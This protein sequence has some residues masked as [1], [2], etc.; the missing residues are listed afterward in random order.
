MII[1]NRLWRGASLALTTAVALA[2]PS[3][4]SAATLYWTP[5]T[6]LNWSDPGNWTPPTALDTVYFEDLLNPASAT[7]NA[8]LVNNIVDTNFTLGTAIYNAQAVTNSGGTAPLHYHT[9]LIPAGVGLGLAGLPGVPALRVGSDSPGYA[10][11]L[12]VATLLGPGNLFVTNNL[13]TVNVGQGANA[14]GTHRAVLDVSLLNSLAVNV[15]NLWVGASSVFDRAAGAVLLATNTTITTAPNVTAPGILLGRAM[16]NSAFGSITLGGTTS[17]NTD[18]LVVGGARS[19]YGANS[20]NFPNVLPG[21][22]L[23]ATFALRGSAGGSSRAAVFS[24]GDAS[25]TETN[26]AGIANG[27]G[28]GSS[29]TAASTADFTAGTVDIL[30]TNLFVGR[31]AADAVAPTT[32][33]SSAGTS[34]GSLIVNNGTVNALNAYVGLKLGTNKSLAIG[35][36]TARGNAILSVSNDLTLASVTSNAVSASSVT[37]TLNVNDNAL[38]QVGGNL[39]NRG[40]TATINLAGGTINLV[41]NG[42]VNVN[43]LAGFG[44]ISGSSSVIVSNTLTLGA[45]TTTFIRPGTLNLGGNLALASAVATK[46]KIG[47]ST[48]PGS[49]INDYLNVGGNLYLTNNSLDLTFVGIPA[50]GTY[51]LVD[52]AG[53]RSGAFNGIF[54]NTTRNLTFTLDQ[55]VNNHIRLVVA[56]G[57]P[58]ALTW[59][60]GV[61]GTWDLTNSA[62]W[63]GNTQK[64]YTF[65][66]VVFDDTGAQPIISIPSGVTVAPGNLTFNNNSVAYTMYA[67]G[68][69]T[70]PTGITKNGTGLVIWDPSGANDFVGPVNINQGTFQIQTTTYTALFGATNKMVTIAN[71]ATLDTYGNTVGSGSGV[72]WPLTFSGS[73]VNGIG[74]IAH[75]KLSSNPTVYS[76]QAT[77]AADALVSVAT[78]GLNMTFAGPSAPFNGVFDL[79]GHTLTVGGFGNIGFLNTLITN[80]GNILVTAPNLFLRDMILDGPGTLTLGTA[81]LTLGSLSGTAWTT[82]YVAKAISIGPSVLQALGGST[83][84]VPINSPISLSGAL[85]VSNAQPVRLAGVISG[86]FGLTKVG[87]N[88][89]N[90]AAANTYTGPTIVSANLL[91][92]EAT[93][94]LANSPL[95][96][97]DAPAALDVTAQPGAYTVPAGQTVQID[98]ALAGN[99]VVPIGATFAGSGL[100]PGSVAVLGGAVTPGVID[101]PRT[102]TVGALTLSNALLTYELDL[103][104]APGGN[105]NDLISVTQLNL[106]GTNVIKIVPLASLNTS[107]GQYTLFNYVGA[108]LPSAITNNF[109][110]VSDTRYTFSFVDPAATPGALMITVSG[111]RDGLV[112]QG[113]VPGAETAWDI[114]TTTNWNN[115]GSPEVF[116]NGDAVVFDDTSL[117]NEVDLAAGTL[118]PSAIGLGNSAQSYTFGGVGSLRAGAITNNGTAGLIFANA[119]N[120]ALSGAGLFL[121]AGS[122]TFSQPTNASFS[123]IL[124]GTSAAALNKQGTNVLSLVGNNGPTYAGAIN[125]NAGTLQPA[126]TNALGFGMVNVAPGATL[127][128]NGQEVD[129]PVIT[130]AGTGV[131]GLGAVN[132]TGGQRTNAL[133]RLTLA[134]DTTLGAQSRWDLEAGAYPAFVGNNYKLTKV[135]PADIWLNAL[136]DTSLGDIDIQQGRLVFAW[137]GTDLGN[138]ANTITVH[139]NASL[140]FAND[141][142]AGA[143]PATI[144]PGGDIEAFAVTSSYPT[145]GANNAYAGNVNFASAGIFR[146]ANLA[147]LSLSGTIQGPAGLVNA[148]RGSLTL[149]GS[150]AYAGDLTVNLGQVT[151]ASSN[152][153]PVGSTVTLNCTGLPSSDGVW[154]YV[155]NTATP[156]TV[157]LSLVSYRTPSGTLTPALTGNGIGVWGGP[158]NMVSMQSDPSQLPQVTFSGNTNLVVMQQVTQSGAPALNL[159]IYGFPGVVQFKAPLQFTGTM[160]MGSQGLG[161]TDLSQMYT[162]LELDS[163]GNAFTNMT[164]WRGKILIGADNALPVGCAMSIPFARTDNDARN[165]VDLHGH[166]Q[167]FANFPGAANGFAPL[168]FGNDSTNGDAALVFSSS[169]TNTWSAWLLDNINTNITTPRKMSLTVTSGGL[170]LA[171]L[172]W[173]NWTYGGPAGATNNTYSGATTVTGGALQ[174]DAPVTNSAITVSGTGVLAGSGPI[175]TPIVVGAGGTLSPGGATTMASAIGILTNYGGL[176]L[177]PGSKCY[178]EV[179][180]TSR[181][182]DWVAGST[183]A[184]GGTLIVT[185]VGAAAFTNGAYVKLFSATNYIAGPVAIQ[186]AFPGAGLMWDVTHLA[187]DGTLHVVPLVVPAVSLPLLRTDGNLSF[188]ITGSLGQPYTVRA[189]T[190]A[191]LPL[192]SWTVLQAGTLPSASYSFSDLTATNYPARFYRVSTP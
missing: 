145:I 97:V 96:R 24:I 72:G 125:V 40:G 181:T 117:T 186:P 2:L 38:V 63:N 46:F 100:C 139:S 177:L 101:L 1:I 156:A 142:S 162:T 155:Q 173:S 78:A 68:K 127:D 60:G 130:V 183:I 62:S 48:T 58:A 14:A 99:L 178:L 69:I 5:V 75:T 128:I 157:P 49:G 8:G 57:P 70:G 73:G 174:V 53:V 12:V 159:N 150:N 147:G 137:G 61:A 26:Y 188:T 118:R 149:S 154:L 146:V 168:W 25:A 55:S 76:P 20:L 113:G 133:G 43:T 32:T 138:P 59:K 28:S 52:Y 35:T 42:T 106:P 151:I 64:F 88:S 11:G 41:S 98:G 39:T 93:G 105:V 71:G 110:L 19:T 108:T 123:G 82:G 160:L 109:V 6:S 3:L 86:G 102:L 23:T 132:N 27:S 184:Y 112:W 9:T 13:T 54:A 169:L 31:S 33:G 37:A 114:K 180:L 84:R 7:N 171:K 152:A 165:I 104:T 134:G 45:A 175:Y 89:L 17:F 122:V 135:G 140:A 182:N 51:S 34:Y 92:L 50:V 164:F 44:T 153:L 141:I 56:G 185:N 87:T 94:S 166:M 124:N 190:D 170:R 67:P 77:L 121:N 36:I 131:G 129:A 111:G 10:S 90:L 65:D 176:T 21:M 81:N 79:A 103:P 4:G 29:A 91:V 172:A 163:P 74:A 126:S 148:D 116:Y 83:L 187:V 47:A 189:S 95:L 18:G 179:N 167:T 120:N 16:T 22:P 85:T 143:K 191:T 107:G 144:L 136:S 30:A 119:A 80:T 66:S 115:L 15:S 192:A 161:I 158:I